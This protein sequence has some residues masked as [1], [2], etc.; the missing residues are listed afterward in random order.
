MKTNYWFEGTGIC[1][2]F[3]KMAFV[4]GGEEVLKSWYF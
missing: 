4:E 1:W 3:V 2:S